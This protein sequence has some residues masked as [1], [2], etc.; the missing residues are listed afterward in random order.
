ML[1]DEMRKALCEKALKKEL[2][3]IFIDIDN[4]I[5]FEVYRI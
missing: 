2:T 3:L 4:N 5:S 1:D